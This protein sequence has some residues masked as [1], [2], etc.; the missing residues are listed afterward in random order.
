MTLG[1]CKMRRI[2]D[3]IVEL[4]PRLYAQFAPPY[5]SIN[6]VHMLL[7]L[8]FKHVTNVSVLH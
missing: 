7:D 4:K 2:M 5:M 1:I 3:S 6:C 8:L